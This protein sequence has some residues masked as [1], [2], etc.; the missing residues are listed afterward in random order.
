M[1]EETTMTSADVIAKWEAAPHPKSDALTLA[2][3]GLLAKPSQ[4]RILAAKARR[5][6][7]AKRPKAKA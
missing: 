6:R 3:I 2:E 4:E 7:R 5:A 1:T